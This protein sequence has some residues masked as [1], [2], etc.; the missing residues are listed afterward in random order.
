MARFRFLGTSLSECLLRYRRAGRHE[1]GFRYGSQDALDDAAHPARGVDIPDRDDAAGLDDCL[2]D[3]RGPV[4]PPV[5]C[6]SPSATSG[7]TTPVAGAGS[8]GVPQRRCRRP[9]GKARPAIGQLLTGRA[10]ARITRITAHTVRLPLPS[11]AGGIQWPPSAHRRHY[12]CIPSEELLA[13]WRRTAEHLERARR[14]LTDADDDGL[15]EYREF[16]EN[17]AVLAVWRVRRNVHR[18]AGGGWRMGGTMRRIGTPLILG[19][20]GALLAGAVAVATP[21]AGV[22]ITELAR[23]D[24]IEPSPPRPR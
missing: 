15:T 18:S 1:G 23:A 14:S 17:N 5:S 19:A 6:G 9:C 21:S 11:R 16:I 8:A 13:S 24:S 20:L 22:A 10:A 2:H 12:A 7:A 3:P 4:P